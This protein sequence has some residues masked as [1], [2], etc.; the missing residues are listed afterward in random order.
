MLH[1]EIKVR[2]HPEGFILLH[3]I[4]DIG[5]IRTSS[6]DR[7]VNWHNYRYTSC[8]NMTIGGL[9]VS[10]SGKNYSGWLEGLGVNTVVSCFQVSHRR[11]RC[12]LVLGSG[13]I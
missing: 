10:L 8:R 13:S 1:D 6:T 5:H 11:K 3:K 12:R 4:P 9:E 7:C 2:F